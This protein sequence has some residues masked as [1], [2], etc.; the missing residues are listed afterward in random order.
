MAENELTGILGAV[1]FLVLI[2]GG[3]ILIPVFLTWY[4]NTGTLGFFAFFIA[5]VSFAIA[6]SVL[7]GKR[8]LSWPKTSGTVVESRL[9]GTRAENTSPRI[10]YSY[11]VQEQQY[12]SSVIS[13][14][15][16]TTV[17]SEAQKI[18]DRYPEGSTVEVYYN[19]LKPQKSTLQPGVPSASIGFLAI[20]AAA[21]LTLL[22]LTFRNWQGVPAGRFAEILQFIS[23]K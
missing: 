14:T 7:N 12:S 13:F 20:F 18:I 4:L 9:D 1:L 21:A 2:L 6:Q 3:F 15:E 10:T 5:L 8:S 16:K 23:R 11:T 19:P 17:K 22:F